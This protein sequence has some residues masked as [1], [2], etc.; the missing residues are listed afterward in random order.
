VQSLHDV[1]NLTGRHIDVVRR[2]A[3]DGLLRTSRIG[4]TYLV[5]DEEVERYSRLN[6]RRGRPVR[7]SEAIVDKEY[8]ADHFEVV[9]MR[10]S[11]PYPWMRVFRRRSPK[12]K[13]EEVGTLPYRKGQ[14]AAETHAWL[15]RII[16]EKSPIVEEWEKDLG[17]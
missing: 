6:I 1:A 9:I 15:G 17:R 5:S 11:G 13:L 16:M 12:S 4:R 7:S 2:H 8:T 3:R 14:T 10:G